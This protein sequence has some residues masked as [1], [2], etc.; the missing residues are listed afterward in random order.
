MLDLIALTLVTFV[1]LFGLSG[2]PASLLIRL[3]FWVFGALIITALASPLT[4]FLI[5]TQERQTA[6]LHVRRFVLIYG[7]LAVLYFFFF[8]V[9]ALS[10]IFR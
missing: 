3:F 6:L 5:S 10:M 7:V 9:L 8:L 1:S 2:N 4:S